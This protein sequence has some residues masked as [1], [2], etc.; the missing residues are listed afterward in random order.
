LEDAKDWYQF[1]VL[2]SGKVSIQIENLV[3]NDIQVL[4]YKNDFCERVGDPDYVTHDGTSNTNKTLS[5][6]AQPGHYFILVWAVD[7][8]SS[9]LYTL[10]VLEP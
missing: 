3:S 8:S 6:A 5:F 9:S 1:N 4:I 7:Y 10:K 2:R